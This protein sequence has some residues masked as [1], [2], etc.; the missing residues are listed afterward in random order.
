MTSVEFAEYDPEAWQEDGILI[1]APHPRL[2]WI[3]KRSAKL[4][5]AFALGTAGV[6]WSTFSFGALGHGEAMSVLEHYGPLKQPG[7]SR[8]ADLTP[9]G[10]WEKLRRVADR[11]PTLPEVDDDSVSEPLV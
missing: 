7:Q 6:F 3:G 1:A 4:A 9:V 5:G 11:W 2:G 8:D 10:Y